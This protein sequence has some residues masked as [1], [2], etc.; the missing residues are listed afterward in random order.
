MTLIPTRPLPV[1]KRWFLG[2]GFIFV[3]LLAWSQWWEPRSR[4]DKYSISETSVSRSAGLLEEGKGLDNHPIESVVWSRNMRRRS[5]GGS[6]SDT[7][8]KPVESTVR[9][10]AVPAPAPV[11]HVP[12]A[13]VSVPPI[14]TDYRT[15]QFA[16]TPF[17][18][19]YESA[20]YR[21]ANKLGVDTPDIYKRHRTDGGG[22]NECPPHDM[23]GTGQ[24]D[25]ATILAKK[26]GSD[27]DSSASLNA[28]LKGAVKML[29]LGLV[30]VSFDAPETLKAA[31]D[32]W[33][34]GGLLD[35]ADDKVAFLNAAK[36]E[37]IALALNAGF[38]VYTPET[39]QVTPLLARH[40]E[41]LKQFDHVPASKL[42]P[43]T[44]MVDG[45][46]ATMVAPSQI[47]SFLE[48]STDLILFA[49][50]DYQL[51]PTSVEQ[52][53]RMLLGAIAMIQSGT[54]VIRL[55]R[56]DDSNREAI[57]D[58]CHSEV[59][60]NSFNNFAGS[61]CEWGSHLNWLAIFCDPNVEERSHGRVKQCMA[62]KKSVAELA[63]N[64]GKDVGGIV[65]GFENT[66]VEPMGALC[67]SMDDSGWS[68]NVALFGREWWVTA[69]GHGAVLTE[70]DN[71]MFELNM[72]RICDYVPKNGLGAGKDG[73][74]RGRICQLEPGMFVHREVEVHLN[75]GATRV[76]VG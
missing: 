49:E 72:V 24:R 46:A 66:R 47:M 1:R 41:W 31:L 56:L 50:K 13:P 11:P 70:G 52:T 3:L 27:F 17:P 67:F 10:V 40:R 48:M 9:E 25:A 59:C 34:D 45:R 8:T 63:A 73:H 18:Q 39:D 19:T 55:R 29:T 14:P 54:N 16:A 44:R 42:F 7:A 61:V 74:D 62:E 32:S 75:N 35:L 37:E 20:L 28:P 38:R 22:F 60:G 5:G 21:E 57:Q 2:P 71:G 65:S 76:V 4:G 68:N 64:G 53:V 33:R 30:V 15:T 6:G 26:A 69:L 51:A 12:V 58:C 23:D 43:A 36:P